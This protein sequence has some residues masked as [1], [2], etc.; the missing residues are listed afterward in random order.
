MDIQLFG[1]RITKPKEAQERKEAERKRSIIE[2]EVDGSHLIEFTA[3]GFST[4][5]TLELEETLRKGSE[6]VK[7]YRE[8]AMHPEA[9]WAIDDICNEAIT[10]SKTD[11]P[12]TV[13]LDQID[14]LSETV[15]EAIRDEF[16]GVLR[17]LNW[18]K[19]SY[20]IFREFYV[21]G[22]LYY[23]KIIDEKKKNDGI[24]ELRAIDASAI[25]K[26]I[27]I[28]KERDPTSNADIIKKVGEYFVYNKTYAATNN[29]KLFY[30]TVKIE[31]D[32]IAYVHSGIPSLDKTM[33]LGY[34]H[35]AIKP[36]NQ[37]R[38]VEDAAVIYRITRAP[39][40]RIFY[41]DVGRLPTQKAEQVV[42]NVMDRHRNKLQYNASTGEI[43]DGKRHMHMLEDFFM[44]RR[45]GSRGTEIV[46]LEGGQH[47]GEMEDVLYF[48]K[49]FYRSLNVPISRL[50]PDG[51]FALGRVAEISR[52][53]VKFT[54][55]VDRVLK[56]LTGLFDDLLGTQLVLKGV[57]RQDE[58]DK[59]K[60]DIQYDFLK[61]SFFTELKQSE[62]WRDRLGLLE[63]VDNHVGKYFP[64]EWVQKNILYMD[65]EEIEE[66]DKQ[67]A[68]E[69][70]ED[71]EAYNPTPM[72]LAQGMLPPDQVMD[73]TATGA[74]AFEIQRDQLDMQADQFDK[75][76]EHQQE[77][78]K[79][80]EKNPPAKNGAAKQDEKEE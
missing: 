10:T 60:E 54:K 23:H 67:I 7:K 68:K 28:E 72:Q 40:R 66:I 74:A 65:D 20:N 44:P 41:V 34:L 56:Q 38:M 37:L 69:Q 25:T 16:N 11:D 53:E 76:L 35:K 61:D 45:E 55:F 27:E 71:P 48:Q 24:A 79:N 50:E 49:K 80:F 13:D 6:Q 2:P 78:Q 12:V 29:N 3:G 4:A 47:L 32:A 64:K 1:F 17:L 58:W 31:P 46:N 14:G 73:G 51:G 21:D 59:I 42:K 15:K 62:I 52:D 19:K 39:E 8:M 63:M 75:N 36:L 77:I 30:Q 22:R 33:V 57:M 5:S 18:G 70:K 9:D 26:V 43:Q